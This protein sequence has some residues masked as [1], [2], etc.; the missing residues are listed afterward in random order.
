MAKA[1]NDKTD[2]RLLTSNNANP[3]N[4]R[5]ITPQQA[6][7]LAEALQEFG[8]LGGIVLNRRTQR[9]V[10]GHQRIDAFSAAEVKV[11]I[12]QELEEPDRTGTVAYGHI[13]MHG[14]RYSYREVDWDEAREAAAN[15]AANKHGGEFDWSLLADLMKDVTAAG[16]SPELTGFSEEQVRDLLA[17]AEPDGSAFVVPGE[18]ESASFAEGAQFTSNRSAI[19]EIA[20]TEKEVQSP[21]L[22]GEIATLCDRHKLTYKVKFR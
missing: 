2:V 12:T 15:M 6:K 17:S 10:G 21:A 8:D 7:A 13:E 19:I 3:R 22:K 9:L 14:T 5:K 20:C 11:E 4:P 18:G 16:I 1:T